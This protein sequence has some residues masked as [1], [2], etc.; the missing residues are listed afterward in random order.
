MKTQYNANGKKSLLELR[1]V[2]NSD[3]SEILE[4][5]QMFEWTEENHDAQQALLR[6]CD[7]LHIRWDELW[8]L[9]HS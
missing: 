8:D 7:K 9:Q 2:I 6:H 4:I 3:V 5:L 1:K